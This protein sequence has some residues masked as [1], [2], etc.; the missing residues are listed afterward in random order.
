VDNLREKGMKN[1]LLESIIT[2]GAFVSLEA[3]ATVTLGAPDCGQWVKE[4]TTG[5][6]LWLIGFLS[7]VNIALATSKIDPLDQ[8]S[9]GG[10]AYLWMDKYCKNNPLENVAKG[11]SELYVELIKKTKNK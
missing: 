5:K 3:S 7:G 9:S 6:Q 8:L 11:A 10:Q 1:K 2:A 4:P